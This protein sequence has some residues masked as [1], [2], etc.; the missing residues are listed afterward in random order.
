M[1]F[2][3]LAT[4]ISVACTD[5]RVDPDTL[6]SIEIL[7]VPP[8]EPF[9]QVRETLMSVHLA[10]EKNEAQLRTQIL[11][12]FGSQQ[13]RIA[14]LI[15]EKTRGI[16]K[17]LLARY[18]ETVSSI[19]PI[20]F[21]EVSTPRDVENVVIQV[22]RTTDPALGV[23]S[24]IKATSSMRSS[25]IRKQ[26]QQGIKEF[27]EVGDVIVASIKKSLSKYFSG[28]AAPGSFLQASSS[29][30][31]QV[32]NLRVGSSSLGDGLVDGSSYPSVVGMVEDEYTKGDLSEDYLLRLILK[33]SNTLV[34]QTISNLTR[35][36]A[37]EAYGVRPLYEKFSF[38]QM[39]AM[40]GLG[41]IA[42]KMP[43]PPAAIATIRKRALEHS[44]IEVDISPPDMDKSLMADQLNADLQGF[45]ILHKS[46]VAANL[47]RKKA[48]VTSVKSRIDKAVK[49]MADLWYRI[50]A[51][52][53]AI[54]TLT[55]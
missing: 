54:A 30:I 44:T 35:S 36:L 52:P 34:E 18:N 8:K 12:S 29:G 27:K 15:T 33:L 39:N 22:K 24:L 32:L 20:S 38:L 23:R 40:P 47:L 26:L 55:Y 51:Q 53:N 1:N 7:L 6:P 11:S 21:A 13:Q 45:K 2:F 14:A 37:P 41:Q 49:R 42:S 46:R 3:L 31:N 25:I 5:V 48:L 10:R 43:I 17:N 9:P 19:V 4:V 50:F 28:S 16:L